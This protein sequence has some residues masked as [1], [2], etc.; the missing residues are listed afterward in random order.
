MF[1]PSQAKK[2]EK[3]L[4][5]YSISDDC[6]NIFHLIS[7]ES[8][9]H[10]GIFKRLSN[11]LRPKGPGENTDDS[12]AERVANVLTSLPYAAA[13][14]YALRKRRNTEGKL[15]GAS[16]VGVA[17]GATAFHLSRGETMRPVCRKA[18]YWMITAS[19]IALLRAINPQMPNIVSAATLMMVPFQPFKI[20]AANI[21]A[22]EFEFG[23]R[24]SRKP[25]LRRAFYKHIA[26]AAVG[27]ACFFLED[28]T[29]VDI[30]LVHAA[31]HCLSAYATATTNV[32]LQDVEKDPFDNDDN[33]K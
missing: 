16:L 30:P 3:G 6:E 27:T 25:A 4:E 10:E 2:I 21:A 31:W 22:M 29:V 18:D 12:T 9:T 8:K 24:A 20:S 13:G 7:C 33:Y 26:S 17:C 32:L 11:A 14:F 1:R 23:R 15:W 19:T 28:S 5:S